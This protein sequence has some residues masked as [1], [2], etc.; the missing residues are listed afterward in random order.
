MVAAN[1]LNYFNGDGQ[2]GGFP[3]SRG[4]SNAAELARQRD[5]LLAELSALDA[6][7]YGLTEVENDGYGANSAVRDLVNGLNALAPPGTTYH[8]I[9]PGF[10]LGGD[11]IKCA[12]IYREPTM[13]PV[14]AAATTTTAPFGSNHPPLAQTFREVASGEKFT[15]VV[16][17]FRSKGGAGT[18]LDAD[19]GDGQGVFNHLRTQQAQV[20]VDWLATDPTG[21]GDADFLILGDLNSYAKEDPVTVIRGAGFVNLV[22]RFEGEGG[23]SF[24][25]GGQFGHLDHA[26]ATPGLLSQ[27]TGAQTWHVNA[28][29]PDFLD[30]NL[31]NK[32]PAQ[33]ALNVGTPFRASDHDPI[34]IGL[35]LAPALTYD[36]WA[37][38]IAW[39]EGA[40]ASPIGDP[41]GD[42][43]S[44]AMEFLL[45]SDPLAPSSA[46]RPQISAEWQ[47]RGIS[48]SPS[49]ECWR[50]E[51]RGRDKRGFAGLDTRWRGFARGRRGCR[52]G[53]V[54]GVAAECRGKNIC[55]AAGGCAVRNFSSSCRAPT[56]EPCTLSS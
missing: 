19:Q 18:G 30:Y 17:H 23:Y 29:E 5:K 51:L 33:Q 14:G 4:A 25:F 52:V 34:L 16:N 1:V 45:H 10:A 48:L 22:E 40:D 54:F 26:L 12:L 50:G 13:E 46:E 28:D 41:D 11:A 31:E 7:I 2:G 24:T 32:S 35:N 8:F 37:A 56:R 47:L 15:V 39:P 53:P 44:N 55:A 38:Q 9:F 6:D 27:V 21:S 42:G 43:L 49:A 20:L 36:A 3:T